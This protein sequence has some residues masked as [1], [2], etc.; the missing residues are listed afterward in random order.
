MQF[1]TSYRW[2]TARA[3]GSLL[4]FCSLFLLPLIVAAL[5]VFFIGYAGWQAARL[6]WRLARLAWHI[7]RARHVADP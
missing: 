5:T 6:L 1:V 2:P 4:P 3:G 7:R